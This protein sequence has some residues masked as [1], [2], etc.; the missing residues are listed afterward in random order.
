MSII[1]TVIDKLQTLPLEKQQEVL[2]FVEF[3]QTKI[4]S[5]NVNQEDHSP[6]SFL[7]AAQEFAGC[8]DG[9]SGALATNKIHLEGLGTE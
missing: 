5:P 8:V 9:G 2:D 3:L 4:L 7:M 6:I 1:Q